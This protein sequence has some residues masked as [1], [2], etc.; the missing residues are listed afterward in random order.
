RAQIEE[1]IGLGAADAILTSAKEGIGVDDV[2]EAIVNR[3]PPPPDTRG[4][5]LRALIFDSWYDSYEGAIAL[6]RV[7]DGEMRQGMK[8]RLIGTGKQG[9]VMRLGY[10]TPHEVATE[11]FGPGEVGLLVPGMKTVAD[12]RVGDTVTDAEAPAAEPLA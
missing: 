10:F 5:P 11:A 2:L 4:K 12:L 7:M 1:V 9:E 3:F 6:V 8:I